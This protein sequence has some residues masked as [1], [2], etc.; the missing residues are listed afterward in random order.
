MSDAEEQ[1]QSLYSPLSAEQRPSLY[2]FLRISRGGEPTS[3]LDASP[4][5]GAPPHS[6]HLPIVTAPEYLFS[7]SEEEEDEEEGGVEG[8][9]VA[10]PA[11]SPRDQM[12]L[13]PR[14]PQV[15]PPLL[16]VSLSRF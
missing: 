2:T 6:P 5:G 3:A 9:G 10:S 12:A 8:A 15:P 11:A 4:G 7:P 13:T 1:P 14:R 16:L